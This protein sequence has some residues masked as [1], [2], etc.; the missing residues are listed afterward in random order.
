MEAY[1]DGPASCKLDDSAS[2]P[3]QQQIAT[4]DELFAAVLK[5]L[6]PASLARTAT[7]LL[8]WCQYATHEFKG[9]KGIYKEDEELGK[10]LGIHPK[11][12]GRHTAELCASGSKNEP[13]KVQLFEVAYGPKPRA[14]SGRVRWLFIRPEGRKIIPT[15][16]KSS[17]RA[18]RVTPIGHRKMLR[19]LY[20]ILT[21]QINVQ[22]N[23][24]FSL[25]KRENRQPLKE[26]NPR[27]RWKWEEKTT[28]EMFRKAW[29]HRGRLIG[30]SK[31]GE[32]SVSGRI[33][34]I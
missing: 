13:G 14:R 29:S 23:S 34:M 26:K 1:T 21:F 30:W 25:Q 28:G 31:P 8:F 9:R 3:I 27:R 15:A 4:K 10:S 32:A 22:E 11:T 33:S 7:E 18:E 17:D 24:L 20:L 16:R 2:V 12:A 19:P 5:Y 6:K